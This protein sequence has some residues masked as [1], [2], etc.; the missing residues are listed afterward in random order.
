MS[1]VVNVHRPR[2]FAFASGALAK[3]I[4]D[5]GNPSNFPASEDLNQYLVPKRIHRDALD[6]A[7]SDHEIAA[8]GIG[9]AAAHVWQDKQ[10][11]HLSAP[12][13]AATAPTPST[14]TP[15]PHMAPANRNTSTFSQ[16]RPK[17]GS[18]CR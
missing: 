6:C 9:D 7:A 15:S 17:P 12:R 5:L 2:E 13:N 3:Q 1:K 10:A 16:H 11:Q 18:A 8:H 14:H 4:G